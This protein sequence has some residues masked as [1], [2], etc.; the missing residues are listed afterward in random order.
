MEQWFCG[1]W[2]HYRWRLNEQG[3]RANIFYRENKQNTCVCFVSVLLVSNMTSWGFQIA[4]LVYST[5]NSSC[6]Y[7]ENY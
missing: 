7:T 4:A 3:K 5:V 1:A 6:V 2:S